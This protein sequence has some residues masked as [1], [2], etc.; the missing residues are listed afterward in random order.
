MAFDTADLDKLLNDLFALGIDG[1]VSEWFRTYLKY[2]KIMV[3][4]NNTLC[5]EYLTKARVP[6]GSVLGYILL[7]IYTI[8][9]HSILE[10]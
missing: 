5:D 3:Y 10:S 8:K 9:L 2:K 1:I 7:L 4:V 6:Q